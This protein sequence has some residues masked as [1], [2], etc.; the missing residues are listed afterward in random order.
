MKREH[1]KSSRFAFSFTVFIVLTILLVV[2]IFTGRAESLWK[3]L[4]YADVGTVW[5]FIGGKTVRGF[6]N[7]NPGQRS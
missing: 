6:G 1:F 2:L 7:A 5:V 3:D 4:L